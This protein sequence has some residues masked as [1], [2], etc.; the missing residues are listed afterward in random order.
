MGRMDLDVDDAL[1]GLATRNVSARKSPGP[2]D[3]GAGLGDLSS[4]DADFFDAVDMEYRR[5]ATLRQE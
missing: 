3:D 1:Y 4:D 2:L 5:L